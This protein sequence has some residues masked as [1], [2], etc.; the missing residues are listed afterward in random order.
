M[1]EVVR[2][3]VTLYDWSEVDV[4][5]AWVATVAGTF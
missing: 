4:Q 1:L 2:T 3:E 5:D